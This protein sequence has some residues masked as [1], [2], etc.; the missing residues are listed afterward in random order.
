MEKKHYVCPWRAGPILATS[1]RKLIHDPQRILSPYLSKGMTAMDI[2]CGMG[3]FT[4]PMAGIA[5]ESGMVIAVD[6]Q[7]QMLDGLKGNAAR[8]GV[9]NITPHLCAP[10]SLR[11]EAWNSSVDFALLFWMLHE[12]PDPDRLLREVCAA[13]R[14][15]GKLLFAE[16]IVHVSA[17]RFQSGLNVITDSGFDVVSRPKIAIS[18]TA[19]LR[20][21]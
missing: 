10:D 16:P 3:F 13:L 21:L 9:E 19:V 18:R 7:P 1:L 20:K 8:A 6:L 12:V 4:L 14:P 15:G 11:V 5:G 2:G 17:E